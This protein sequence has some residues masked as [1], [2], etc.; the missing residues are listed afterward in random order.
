VA[1]DIQVP[2]ITAELV[3]ALRLMGKVTP[4][5]DLVVTPTVV[6]ADLSAGQNPPLTNAVVGQIAVAAGG[7][8]QFSESRL[9]VNPGATL[10]MPKRLTVSHEGAAAAK[11]FIILSAATSFVT[12]ASSIMVDGRRPST[13]AAGVLSGGTG[14]V[15]PPA[16][17]MLAFT[18]PVGQAVQY[19][20]TDWVLGNGQ[21]VRSLSA[22]FD[23]ANVAA[24]FAWEWLEFS[25]V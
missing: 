11:V 12:V 7:A 2:R 6:V 22:R 24:Q 19:D 8:G 13:G 1:T 20:F 3:R 16:T 17:A 25:E 5:L 9:L 18:V 23:V 21:A 4:A 10:L 15:A 14:A